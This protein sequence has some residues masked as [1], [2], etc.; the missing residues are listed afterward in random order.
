MSIFTDENVSISATVSSVAG[1]RDVTLCWSLV[2]G[3][4]G[5][6]VWVRWVPIDSQTFNPWIVDATLSGDSTCH[7]IVGVPMPLARS[8]VGLSAVFSD[9]ESDRSEFTFPVVED[10]G[11]P[12]VL[13]ARL[14]LNILNPEDTSPVSGT[15]IWE[16]SEDAAVEL[17]EITHLR[18]VRQ[19][20][21]PVYYLSPV[22]GGHWV[23]EGTSLSVT[24]VYPNSLFEVLGGYPVGNH[25]YALINVTI[26]AEDF[27]VVGGED[28][29]DAG[30][31]DGK[32]DGGGDGKEGGGENGDKSINTGG[33]GVV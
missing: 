20:E 16:I 28:G 6:R 12:P 21:Q 18:K 23:L 32:E 24:G 11:V 5:Y 4:I 19:G 3:A 1:A 27:W 8:Q 10:Q 30:E 17:W 22:P 31:E 25:S 9:V 14:D 2:D 7:T 13:V 29:G 26:E 15:L 33:G